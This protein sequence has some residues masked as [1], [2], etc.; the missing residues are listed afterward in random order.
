MEAHLLIALLAYC[1][2]NTLRQQLSKVVGECMP[3][4]VLEHLGTMQI[5]NVLVPATDGPELLL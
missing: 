3:R 4:T 1:L 2:A 5:G